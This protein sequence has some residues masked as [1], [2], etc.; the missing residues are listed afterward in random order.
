MTITKKS[1]KIGNYYITME[2]VT[3]YEITFIEVTRHYYGRFETS[4]VYSLDDKKNANACYRRYK[5]YA[6]TH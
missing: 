1:E 6:E 3:R 5:K 4:N 2:I